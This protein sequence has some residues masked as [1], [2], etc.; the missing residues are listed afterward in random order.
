MSVCRERVYARSRSTCTS[1]TDSDE[2]MQLH[3]EPSAYTV[4]SSSHERAKESYLNI[5]FINLENKNEISK[6]EKDMKV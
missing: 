1:S 4:M 6:E 3:S 2:C 5:F